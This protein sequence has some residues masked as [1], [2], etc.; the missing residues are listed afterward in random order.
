MVDVVKAFGLNGSYAAAD[1]S[2]TTYVLVAKK[3][4]MTHDAFRRFM[5]CYDRAVLEMEDPRR[6]LHLLKTYA[7]H[8]F[9]MEEV[10]Q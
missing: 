7:S 6:L 2:V 1:G 9:T 5:D 3:R 8:T 4:L 10:R